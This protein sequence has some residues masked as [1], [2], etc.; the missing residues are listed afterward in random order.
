MTGRCTIGGRVGVREGGWVGKRKDVTPHDTGGGGA[1]KRLLELGKVALD[2]VGVGILDPKTLRMETK[3][4]VSLFL[5]PPRVH[6]IIKNMAYCFL[7]Y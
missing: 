6:T 1:R 4:E 2:G 7:L 3:G 5:N